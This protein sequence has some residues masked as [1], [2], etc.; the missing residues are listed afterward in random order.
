[1]VKAYSRFEWLKTTL[2]G[3]PP[4][5]L[6]EFADRLKYDQRY[7]SD[8]AVKQLGYSITPFSKG[9]EKTVCYLQRISHE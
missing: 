9:L 6:P 7:S 2:T 5:L 4:F 3:L 1:M 8:K